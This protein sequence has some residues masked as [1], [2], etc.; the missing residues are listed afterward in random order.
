M[1]GH[2]VFVVTVVLCLPAFAGLRRLR[3][4]LSRMKRLAPGWSRRRF[5]RAPCPAVP[6]FPVPAL[7][8]MAAPPGLA[9]WSLPMTIKM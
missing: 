8:A 5:G 4:L 7:V 3:Y 1:T 9:T 2:A 6:K